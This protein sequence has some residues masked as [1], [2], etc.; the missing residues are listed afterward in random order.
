[1]YIGLAIH[2]DVLTETEGDVSLIPI[3]SGYR[4]R[5]TLEL[6]LVTDY[7]SIIWDPSNEDYW[8]EIWDSNVDGISWNFDDLSVTVPL[9]EVVSARRFSEDVYDSFQEE[10]QYNLLQDELEQE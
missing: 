6:E 4:H 3:Y 2:V 10:D 1:M 7:S 9:N 8:P 5:E